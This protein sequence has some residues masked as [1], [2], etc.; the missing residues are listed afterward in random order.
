MLNKIEKEILVLIEIQKKR[1][2]ACA[3]IMVP[4][5]TEE[6]LLQP[7]DFPV[8]EKHPHFRHEEGILEGLQTALATIRALSRD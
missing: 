1:L 4:Y 6:D 8:L 5:I 7:N 3:E 2:M